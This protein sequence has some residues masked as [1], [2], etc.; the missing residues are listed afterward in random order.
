MPECR[1]VL[2]KSIIIPR[3][4]HSQGV[5]VRTSL[6]ITAADAYVRN[7]DA[8]LRCVLNFFEG[9]GETTCPILCIR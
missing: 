1:T 3:P 4:M 6:R 5:T 8:F 2:T 7:M 9:E